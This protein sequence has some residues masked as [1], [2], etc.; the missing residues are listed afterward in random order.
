MALIRN[1]SGHMVD[2]LIIDANLQTQLVAAKAE[3]ETANEKIEE[4]QI[5]LRQEQRAAFWKI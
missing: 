5:R 3:L 1:T 2:E 4:L